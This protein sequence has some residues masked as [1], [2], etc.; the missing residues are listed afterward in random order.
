MDTDPPTDSERHKAIIR[1]LYREV[2]TEACFDNVADLLAPQ[3][4]Y[5]VRGQSFEQVPESLMQIVQRWKEAFPDLA[6][7]VQEVIA[8]G[9]R[10]SARL[11]YR[12]TQRGEWKGIPATGRRVEVHEMLFFRFEEGRIAE[13][14]EVVD[15]HSLRQQ[16]R[17]GSHEGA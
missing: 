8:E 14:W 3:I 5:H 16:L 11:V 4:T 17:G 1:Q 6:F 9:D 7:E 2:W 10:A 12:G 15:E 13:V